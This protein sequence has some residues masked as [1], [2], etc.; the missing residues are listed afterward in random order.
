MPPKP[1]LPPVEV[2]PQLAE[3]EEWEELQ[4]QRRQQGG[5][6]RMRLLPVICLTSEMIAFLSDGVPLWKK[7]TMP[8]ASLPRRVL[9]R[10]THGIEAAG[11]DLSAAGQASEHVDLREAMANV[12]H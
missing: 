8:Q 10:I 2:D 4:R 1:Q 6:Q 3:I 11:L 9:P 7:S 5:Q 12:L